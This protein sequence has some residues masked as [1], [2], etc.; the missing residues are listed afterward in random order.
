MKNLY[1]TLQKEEFLHLG[2]MH[3]ILDDAKD[4]LKRAET[5]RG[6]TFRTMFVRHL[7]IQVIEGVIESIDGVMRGGAEQRPEAGI[8]ER[9]SEIWDELHDLVEERGKAGAPKSVVEA[10]EDARRAVDKAQNSLSDADILMRR[11][12]AHA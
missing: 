9:L 1:D 7:A 6:D 4:A 2:E 8:S 12:E 10:L 5:D 11:E 3:C